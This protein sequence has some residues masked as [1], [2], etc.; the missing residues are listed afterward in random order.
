M[1]EPASGVS[2]LRGDM[3]HPKANRAREERENL[4]RQIEQSYD[5]IARTRKIITL[6]EQIIEG[7]ERK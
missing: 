4:Q 6:L 2:L 3:A 7:A 1:I 5:T